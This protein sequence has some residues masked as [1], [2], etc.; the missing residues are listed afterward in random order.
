VV[1]AV[2]GA[3]ESGPS[4]EVS[5]TPS[6]G[7]NIIF[8]EIKTGGSSAST[9]VSTS[10]PLTGAT[11][12]LYL[13]AIATKA[14]SVS[15][16]SVSGLGLTWTLVKAQCAGRNQT[17]VE[18]WKA[19][20]TPTGSGVVTA[21]L[22]AAPSNAVIEVSRYSAVN[23]STPIGN[24]VSANTKGVNGVCSGGVDTASYSV[25]LA[26]AVANSVVYGAVAMRNR[27]HTPGSGYTERAEVMQGSSGEAAGEAVMDRTV[28][29]PATL[30]VNGG[31]S[32]TVDW[33]VVAVELRP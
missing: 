20:G 10:A 27:A 8:Q 7:G 14:G 31:F 17:R 5:A 22:S 12:N 29:T 24:V 32:G 33:A 26:T 19:I 21:T 13:A 11:N 23:A 28:A 9:T 3:G 25:N 16:K 4:N 18:V 30:A 6:V 2:N 1:T 15:G